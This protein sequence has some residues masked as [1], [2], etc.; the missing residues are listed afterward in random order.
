MKAV[1]QEKIAQPKELISVLNRLVETC[2]DGQNGFQDAAS[3]LASPELKTF[4]LEQ[5]RQRAQYIGELQQTVLQLGG[6]PETSGTAAAVL[7]RAWMDLKSS[8]GAGDKAIMSAVEKGEDAALE[9]YDSAIKEGLP[10]NLRPLIE[11]QYQSVKQVH[12]QVKV[13]RD[14]LK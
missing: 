10:V 5:S 8:F 7:H 11:R 9:Q 3:N 14:R 4:C 13:M 2:R 12:D 1:H 6:D